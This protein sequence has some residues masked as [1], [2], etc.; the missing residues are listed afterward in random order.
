MA[1]WHL[2]YDVNKYVINGNRKDFKKID[3]CGL[4]YYEDGCIEDLS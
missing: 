2:K 1:N 4:A 3:D